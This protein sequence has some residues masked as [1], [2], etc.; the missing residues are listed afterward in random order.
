MRRILPC[1]LAAILLPQGLSGQ[2]FAIAGQLGSTGIGGSAVFGVNP[3]LNLRGSVGF[4]PTDFS[5]EIEGIDF[6]VEAPTFLRGTVDLYPTGGI[7]YLSGGFLYLTDSGDV[8][9]TGTLVDVSK[10]FGDD[11]YLASEV[12]DLRGAF[13]LKDFQPYVGIGFGNP[14]GRALGLNVDLGIAF[15]EVPNVNLSATGPIQN[16]PEFQADLRAEEQDIQDEIPDWAKYY[17]VLSLSLS[18]G[19]GN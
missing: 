13:T 11:E 15:G 9:V 14:V 1:L 19:F 5:T 7:F 2:G 8:T 17:P 16:D 3:K 18:I 6:S 4:I 10:E 12:G